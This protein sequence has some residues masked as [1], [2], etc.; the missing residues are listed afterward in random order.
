MN[1]SY[2]Y[3]SNNNC[4]LQYILG[5][6]DKSALSSSYYFI[7]ETIFKVLHILNH[8]KVLLQK[9]MIYTF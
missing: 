2:L 5:L 6:C 7:D 9:C 1:I 3:T 8:I 4:S